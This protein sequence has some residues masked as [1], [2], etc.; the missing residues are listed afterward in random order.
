M[1]L[2]GIKI[3]KNESRMSREKVVNDVVVAIAR[4]CEI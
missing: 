1:T 4:K 2:L 3:G